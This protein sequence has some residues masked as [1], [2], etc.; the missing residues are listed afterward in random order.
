MNY[1]DMH[2]FPLS[3]LV[4]GIG[5]FSNLILPKTDNQELLDELNKG[6]HLQILIKECQERE[7]NSLLCMC[8]GL[9]NESTLGSLK[10]R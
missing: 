1:L 9:D 2:G 10:Y 3:V 6:T 5:L 8:S 4:P 7:S